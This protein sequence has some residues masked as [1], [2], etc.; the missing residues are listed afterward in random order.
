MIASMRSLSC[1]MAAV[2]WS[3]RP[4][5]HPDQERV[6]IGEPPG[7]RFDQLGRFGAQPLLGQIGQL[8]RVA[9]AVGQGLEHRPAGDPD[10]VGGH[11]GQF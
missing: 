5:W 8:P 10:D 2:C 4:R 6:V 3:I 1:L 9:L 11:R 7:Q